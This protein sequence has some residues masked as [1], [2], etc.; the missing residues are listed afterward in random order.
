MA[1]PGFCLAELQ[2]RA[3]E[4]EAVLREPPKSS[5]EPGRKALE[6]IGQHLVDR[7]A[8]EQPHV[9][10]ARR[11]LRV[12]DRGAGPARQDDERDQPTEKFHGSIPSALRRL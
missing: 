6:L 1:R 2:S 9:G 7:N 11:G 10:L 4:H 3:L 5:V 12:L 8:D